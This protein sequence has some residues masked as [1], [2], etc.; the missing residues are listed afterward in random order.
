MW[1]NKVFATNF[2]TSR[3]EKQI[4]KKTLSIHYDRL[5]HNKCNVIVL[6]SVNLNM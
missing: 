6:K 2:A 5:G 1:A 4:I 3:K